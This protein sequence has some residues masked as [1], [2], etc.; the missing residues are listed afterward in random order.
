MYDQA[1]AILELELDKLAPAAKPGTPQF[2]LQQAKSLG[3]SFLRKARAMGIEDSVALQDLRKMARVDIVRYV[4]EPGTKAEI[5]AD[6]R[7][8]A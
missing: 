6:D 2:A 8:G 5:A 1:A 4:E 3:L 7:P